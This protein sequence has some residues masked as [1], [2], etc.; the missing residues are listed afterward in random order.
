MPWKEGS[1]YDFQNDDELVDRDERKVIKQ[2]NNV[3]AVYFFALENFEN[4]L[5]AIS[6]SLLFFCEKMRN[7]RFFIELESNFLIT[8]SNKSQIHFFL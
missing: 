7:T 8:S 1:I 6:R 5:D 4:R 2:K 3:N